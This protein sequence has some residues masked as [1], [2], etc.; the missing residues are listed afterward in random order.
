MTA[1]IRTNWTRPEISAIYYQPILDLLLQAKKCI[2]I[3]TLPTKCRCAG[4]FPSRR[5]AVR[6]TAPIA[7]RAPAT[8][9]E[10]SAR[11]L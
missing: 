7:H 10:S 11:R 4:C 2:A 1:M 9:P 5:A 6:K 3:T 8:P